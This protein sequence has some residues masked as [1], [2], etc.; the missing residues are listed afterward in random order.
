MS[1]KRRQVLSG[2][3]AGAVS[4]ATGLAS[5]A[6]AAS[7]PIRIGFLPA[8]TGASSSTGVAMNRGTILAVD[9]INAAGGVDGRKLELIVRDTQS[10]PTKAV[11]GVAELI[12]R[13]KVHVIW[14]PLNSGEALAATPL[15]ARESMPQV[16][17]CWVDT[18]IDV[19][20]YPYAFRNAPSNQQ[21]GVAANHYVV[22]VLKHKKVAVVSDTTGYGTAS[23]EAYVPMLKEKGATVV[24]QGNVDAANPDLKPELLRMRDGGAEAIMPWSVNAGFLARI[25]NTR[26]QMGWDVPIVGQT[27]LGSGQTKALLEKPEYWNKVYSNNFRNCCY[28]SNG[29]LPPRAA[30]FVEHLQKTKVEMGD[31]LLWWIACG[32]DAPHMIAETVKAAG[33]GPKDIVGYWNKLKAWP[34]IY[35]DITWTPEQHNGF[36]DDEVV[37]CEVNSFRD[38]AFNLAPGYGS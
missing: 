19:K 13:Q 17:P 11:N 36:P 26:G 8:L 29:K 23:V 3:A 4:L 2:S 27:T 33:S 20:K 1:I 16:H 14:G 5:P 12:H 22:D 37:M 35:G 7:E 30:A 38:G 9:E 25:C 21:I 24:Y 18:L 15:I 28:G 34:G 6:I 31:T 32:Y 10:D